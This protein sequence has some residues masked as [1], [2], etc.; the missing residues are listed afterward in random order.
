[1][2]H[3]EPENTATIERELEAVEAALRAGAADHHDP[4][5]RELQDLGLLLQAEA[6]EP[7]AE[8]AEALE[9]RMR[10]GFP[11]KPGSARALADEARS[12]L[13]GAVAWPRNAVRRMPPPRRLL[14]AAAALMTVVVIGIAVTSVDV[15]RSGSDDGGGDGGGGGSVAPATSPRPRRT[16]RRGPR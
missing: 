8:F 14:P 1:M 11:A 16:S 7:D 2:T 9:Q 15:N 3:P 4:F 10:K 5:V 13:A 12:G 6:S